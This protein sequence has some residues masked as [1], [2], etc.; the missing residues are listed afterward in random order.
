MKNFITQYRL[1]LPLRN[2]AY[3]GFINRQ[4]SG[5]GVIGADQL[6][7]IDCSI[8]KAF[9]VGELFNTLICTVYAPVAP[10]LPMG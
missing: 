3:R 2:N 1:L 4:G 10:L 8:G 7:L 6:H 9:V 5:G